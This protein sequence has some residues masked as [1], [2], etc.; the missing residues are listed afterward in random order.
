MADK[1]WVIDVASWRTCD[2]VDQCLDGYIG[3]IENLPQD[4]K[5]TSL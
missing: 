4:Y 3:K 2:E 5:K 1:I